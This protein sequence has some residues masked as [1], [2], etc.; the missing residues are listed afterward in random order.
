[1]VDLGGHTDTVLKQMSM[2]DEA[3]A[4]G[5]AI[6]PDC[7]MG[8]G[9][10]NTMGVYTVERLQA[11]GAAPREVRLW[12]GGLPQ[13]PTEPWGYQCSFHI[14]GLTN[15]YDGQ[16]LVL[17]DGRVTYVDTLTE[18]E[19]V[20]FDGIGKLEAFVTSGGTSTVP[21]T[22]EGTLHVYENKTCRYPGHYA[23]FRAFKELG[24][25]D[26]API[27]INP[28]APP[29]SPRQFYHRLLA[30]QVEVEQVIDICVMRAKG[31]GEKDGRHMSVVVELVDRY[32]DTTGFTAM[33]RLT[34]WHAA[35][36]AEF[37]ARGEI[38]PGVWPVE[39]AISATRFLEKVR[40]RGFEIQERSEGIG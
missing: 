4:G 30:P 14:N 16:A 8:P 19:V 24:L 26:E 18:M 32:D 39:K 6:V 38:E 9:M 12:D 23:R 28:G 34:G 15:E 27:A 36:M 3:K 2:S 17:R 11:L 33:E 25:F 10:N 1:M 29:I 22:F 20:E 5:V 7:G 31:T 21:Y 40:E 13:N 37:I 35:I